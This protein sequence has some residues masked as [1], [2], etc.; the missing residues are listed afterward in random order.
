MKIII[1]I[2]LL[3]NFNFEITPS[4]ETENKFRQL[5]GNLVDEYGQPFPGQTIIIKGTNIGT[6][7]DFEGNFCLIVPK[8]KAIFIELPFCFEQIFREIKPEDEFI[9]LKIGKNKRISKRSTQRWKKMIPELNSFLYKAYKSEEYEY[10]KN[11]F[12]I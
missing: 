12:C 2:T 10:A 6:I 11:N 1:I 5:K 4:V 9:S 3:I 8:N 7:T